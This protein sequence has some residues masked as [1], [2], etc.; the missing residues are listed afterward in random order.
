MQD[1]LR[2]SR[3]AF[4]A[5]T[6]AFL[7]APCWPG[8]SN[9]VHAETASLKKGER[10]V[11]L[12]DSITQQGNRQGGYV[13]LVR[14]KLTAEHADLGVEVIGAG[15]SGNKVPDLQKR[16]DRD[17]LGKNPSLVVV[18]I[19][20]NDVWHS[21]RGRGTDKSAYEDGLRDLIARIRDADARVV[22]CTP[23]VI[24]EKTDGTNDLDKMLDEYAAI[25]RK[26]AADSKVQLLDLRQ[27]FLEHLKAHNP[28]NK[29][30]GI[31][32]GD[33]VH[34]NAAGNEFVAAQ[35]LGALGV[36]EPKADRRLRHVVLF[37]FKDGTTDDQVEE[38]VKAFGQL[39][40]KIDAI[41]DFEC[42]TDVSVENKAAGFTH[43]FLVTFGSTEGRDAYLP[44]PA[45]KEFVS[46]V[47][48]LLDKVL[49]FDY[50]AQD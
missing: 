12:G 49:V 19:G 50:W 40:S 5:A 34:L 23:S 48:P 6:A 42:G 27:E 11:F 30:K 24:G 44:Y 39:P 16:L 22:L 25:S 4:W 36:T 18:Y 17:V 41:H 20:I 21:V 33:G 32:T 37:K 43:C 7:S 3:I 31:L 38:I 13:A 8:I 35:V 46:I 47:G 14:G 28:D 26:V 29:P 2:Q 45:H 1:S 10:I 15:I 9:H